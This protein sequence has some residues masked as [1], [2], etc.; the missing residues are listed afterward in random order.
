M[1]QSKIID[2]T[3]T[4]QCQGMAKERRRL[5][6]A[7]GLRRRGRYAP[8]RDAGHTQVQALRRDNTPS[9]PEFGWM[10]DGTMLLLELYGGGR[11]LAK[12]RAAPSLWCSYVVASP[13]LLACFILYGFACRGS[14]IS[15]PYGRGLLVGFIDQ[16]TQ[17][18][19][20]NTPSRWVRIVGVWDTG[21]GPACGLVVRRVPLGAGP[22][23]LGGLCAVLSIVREWPSR[24][25]YSGAPSGR[26][27]LS[28]AARVGAL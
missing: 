19:N 24:V 28:S 20:G 1:E 9:P 13:I 5:E 3:E 8:A 14:H 21:L 16:P 17:G 25:V 15:C 12:A 26:R 2:T 11:R 18:Y 22:A 7:G 23:C 6:G 4:Y 27:S 10:I